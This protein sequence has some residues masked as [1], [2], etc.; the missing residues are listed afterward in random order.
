M[1]ELLALMRS[2]AEFEGYLD[3]FEVDEVAI[4][5][6]GFDTDRPTFD[7]FVAVASATNRVIGMAVTYVIPWTYD[8]RPTLV[9]KELFVLPEARGAGVGAKLMREVARH[10]LAIEARRIGWTVIPSNSAAKSFYA[11]LGARPETE[12][13]PWILETSEIANLADDGP[14]SPIK[15][16]V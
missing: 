10:A 4:L 3:A 1:H 15:R 16:K 11:S 14:A 2:L 8:L 13:E 5:R 12:W 9:L 6:A 7:A